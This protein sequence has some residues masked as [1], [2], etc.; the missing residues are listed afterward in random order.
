MQGGPFVPDN[1]VTRTPTMAIDRSLLRD[2]GHQPLDQG[3]PFVPGQALD[4]IGMRCD[5]ECFLTIDGVRPNRPPGL[6]LPL[7]E[8][9]LLG[10]LG[11]NL[12][13]GVGVAMPQDGAAGLFFS[14]R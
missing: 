13:A 6:V 8:H 5:I 1:D 7:G 11:V 4:G 14:A 9:F 2:G 3:A 12:R 10:E